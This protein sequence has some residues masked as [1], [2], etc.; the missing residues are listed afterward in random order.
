MAQAIGDPEEIRS[1]S[2]ALEHY[3]NTVEEETGRLNSAFEQLGESWQDQQRASFEETYKQLINA[4]HN[5]KENASEQIPH[6]RTMA[7]DLS[8]Y[9]GR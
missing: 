3:L 2:N 6:L 9:L 7:E 4:L 5:F 1:F 8:T